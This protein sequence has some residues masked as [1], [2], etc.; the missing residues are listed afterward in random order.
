MITKNMPIDFV[1]EIIEKELL[2][3][4]LED[5]KYIGGKNQINLFSFYE[6]VKNQDEVNRYVETFR[7]LTKQA[8]RS[9]LISNGVLLAP[10]NPTI[11]NLYSHLIIPLTFTAA[12]RQTLE[13]R[14]LMIATFNNLFERLKGKSV[15]VAEMGDNSLFYLPKIGNKKDS[16]GM[17]I[18]QNGI[19]LGDLGQYPF[20][21]IYRLIQKSYTQQNQLKDNVYY[22]LGTVADIKAYYEN[23]PTYHYSVLGS[24]DN[25]EEVIAR[26]TKSADFDD[27]FDEFGDGGLLIG[28]TSIY[29]FDPQMGMYIP[30][31]KYDYTEL[32]DDYRIYIKCNRI[33][34]I[35]IGFVDILPLIKGCICE[36]DSVSEKL[37]SCFPQ[38]IS[39]YNTNKCEYVYY[40]H[41]GLL[42][43]AVE[44]AYNNYESQFQYRQYTTADDGEKP[45]LIPSNDT[46]LDIYKLSLSFDSERIENPIT[47]NEKETCVIS[48]GGSATLCDKNTKLGNDLVQVSFSKKKI[49][50]KDNDFNYNENQYYFEPLELPSG[51][52]IDSGINQLRSNKFVK[53]SIA[54][55]LGLSLQYTFVLDRLF[56]DS[57][58]LH[59]WFEYARYGIN[60]VDDTQVSPNT[61]YEIT[62]TWSSNGEVKTYT[63]LGK[64]V[65]SIDIENNENDVMTITIPIQ[66]QGENN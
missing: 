35:S 59:Q 36:T 53:N 50:M 66:I 29:S 42:K 9:H 4:H 15:N 37:L 20:Y 56:S 1:R 58:L 7:D 18:P 2:Y 43:I 12:F 8:N 61:L 16:Y 5:D 32:E 26:I 65:E 27:E 34:D 10:E 28:E 14:D 52:N 31:K 55:G 11:T 22:Y 41:N 39:L 46:L 48:F 64:I 21:T 40:L 49:V 6:Q 33:R 45:I 47:L 62:E 19:Y 17:M 30:T 57:D 63:F 13:D 3:A 38:D 54:S 24:Q 60:G 44:K 23:Q 51:N 25:S